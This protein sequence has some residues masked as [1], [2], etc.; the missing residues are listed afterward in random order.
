MGGSARE[1]V[2]L[3]CIGASSQLRTSLLIAFLLSTW[4]ASSKADWVQDFIRITC[5]PEARYFQFEYAPM[6][7]P[8]V[9]LE[10]QFDRKRQRKRMLA[11]RKHGF[12][13][14]SKL[15]YECKLPENV[16][17]ISTTQPPASNGMCGAAQPIT[18]NLYRNNKPII[19]KVVA[20]RDCLGNVSTLQSVEIS[21]ELKGWESSSISICLAPQNGV[22]QVLVN[23][24]P[25][26]CRNDGD[27]Y[28]VLNAIP[29]DQ[30]VIEE[31]AESS[32]LSNQ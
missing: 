21:D 23:P 29:I 6:S 19:T 26:T 32:R 10:T 12:Y 13:N 4:S 17:K 15:D 16:Y 18:I 9:L 27:V 5:I 24:L 25:Q 8:R 14:P 30:D 11:W 1:R 28:S 31:W 2:E 3:F 22:P 7:G 20:G